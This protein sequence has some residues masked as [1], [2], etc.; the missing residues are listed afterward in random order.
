VVATPRPAAP[1]Q[2][3]R[4]PDPGRN[5]AEEEPQTLKLAPEPEPARSEEPQTLQ[6]AP[7]TAASAQKA[8]APDPLLG[9]KMAHYQIE[10]VLGQGGMGKVYKARNINLDKIC[11]I[12]ILPKEFASEDPTTVER[13]LREARSAAKVEHPNVLPVSFVGKVGDSYFIEM[14]YVDGGTLYDVLKRQGRLDSR[15]AARIV[16]DIAAGL[17]A[18]HERGIIHRDIKPG[19]VMLTSKGH[20]FIMD[21]GLAK[22]T[23]ASIALTKQ[24]MI[25]GTPLYMSPEQAMSR[26]LDQRTDIYS[27]GVM[28]YHMVT[29]SPPYFSNSAVEVVGQHIR[30]PV[31]DPTQ[32]APETPPQVAAI[33]QRMMA[34]DPN[35]RHQNCAEL[36]RELEAFLAGGG[37]AVYVPEAATPRAE[38]AAARRAAARKGAPWG[39]VVGVVA[40]IIALGAVAAYI[41]VRMG[42]IQLP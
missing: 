34:K 14:Q 33:I 1:R 40:G 27:L 35:E 23:Q 18:A 6:L 25:L 39:I 36:V 4:G 21:F 10:A 20:V 42:I 7:E 17:S 2:A 32:L 11:A 28:F 9:K 30:A 38:R 31:P 37:A 26:P 19:N 13:F 5:A 8:A 16:R 3:L 15:E 22:M 24:G 12:K 41:L 29:G